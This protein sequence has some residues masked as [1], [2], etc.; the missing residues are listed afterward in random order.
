MPGLYNRITTWI[1]NQV[2]THTDLNAEFDNIKT[3]FI[4][5]MIDDYSQ[6]TTQMRIQTTP[7]AQ[8]SESLATST[9]GELERLRFVINRGFGGTYWYDNPVATLATL[10]PVSFSLL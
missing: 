6:D 10:K 7:G 4:P 5:T 2:L 9:S 8:G 3:N 1:Q